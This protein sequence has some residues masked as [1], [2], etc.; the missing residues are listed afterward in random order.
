M[1]CGT[2][3]LRPCRRV[4]Q[5]DS[6][7]LLHDPLSNMCPSD[8]C[9]TVICSGDD[10]RL[11]WDPQLSTPFSQLL[12]MSFGDE[13]V[14]PGLQDE[15]IGRRQAFSSSGFSDSFEV[16]V[17]VEMIAEERVEILVRKPFFGIQDLEHFFD[18]EEGSLENQSRRFQMCR[19]DASCRQICRKSRADTLSPNEQDRLRSLRSIL[20]ICVRILVQ[21][22]NP[23][24]G[25]VGIV[26]D[27]DFRGTTAGSPVPPVTE[28]N[29]GESNFAAFRVSFCEAHSDLFQDPG[30]IWQTRRQR[31]GVA[32]CIS[33][34][35]W[36]GWT[37]AGR[38]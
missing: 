27:A 6:C 5:S 11:T 8:H 35:P 13:L 29:L 20:S 32:Y 16:P 10:R 12:R 38:D 4:F 24:N 26:I 36:A 19:D 17:A 22:I 1:D 33:V 31:R 18:R 2:G 21:L 37:R 25:S 3:T 9:I 30:M 14:S 23:I 34:S 7:C 28:T 15:D